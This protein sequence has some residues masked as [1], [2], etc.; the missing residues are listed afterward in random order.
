MLFKFNFF[1]KSLLSVVLS[2][3]L[4][5]SFGFEFTVITILAILVASKT[6]DI[7]FLV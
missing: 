1:W 5:L 6:K 4:Y 7:N 2:W 3:L